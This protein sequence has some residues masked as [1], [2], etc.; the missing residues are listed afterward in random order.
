MVLISES[1]IRSDRGP[2][3]GLQ[4]GD[5]SQKVGKIKPGCFR[6]LPGYIT[7]FGCYRDIATR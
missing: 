3:K 7:A 1:K 4:Y 6:K 5:I 2:M